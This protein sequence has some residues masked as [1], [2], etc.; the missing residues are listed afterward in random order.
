MPTLPAILALLEPVT[1][2]RPA[3]A[4]PM[5]PRIWLPAHALQAGGLITLAA[6]FLADRWSRRDAFFGL[7]AAVAALVGLRHVAGMG[8]VTGLLDPI[9]ARRIITG[10]AAV[11][12]G[13][14]IRAVAQVVPGLSARGQAVA[15]LL[16]VPGLLR[17]LLLPL[18]AP[19]SILLNGASLLVYLGC[20]AWMGRAMLRGARE[21]D[22]ASR[23][24]LAALLLS[25]VPIAVEVSVVATGRRFPISGLFG[26]VLAV[27]L[28]NTRHA[29]VTRKL[30]EEAE[31]ARRESA[32]WRGLM[33]G[34]TWRGAEPSPMMETLFGAAWKERLADRMEGLDGVVYD[35]RRVGAGEGEEVGLVQPRGEAAPVSAGFLSGWTVAVALE[36]AAERGRLADC[37]KAWGA[38]VLAWGPLL[39]EAGP[40]PAFLLWGHD[41]SAVAAW[42]GGDPAR[43]RTRWI[44]AGGAG[45]AGPHRRLDLPVAPGALRE[46]LQDLLRP[47]EPDSGKVKVEG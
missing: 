46:A 45:V 3:F 36:D 28:G 15:T 32:A 35:V 43:R 11:I 47:G 30:R 40:Y 8:E 12:M 9:L 21:G 31:A 7:A 20:L 13:V 29:L 33:P 26:L 37:L 5:D 42:R 34:L 22:E 25:L 41:P 38:E 14:L 44:Q 27:A 23:R 4:A 17:C 2:L 39:P 16:L 19:G 10:L 24:M 6:F 18:D 1:P